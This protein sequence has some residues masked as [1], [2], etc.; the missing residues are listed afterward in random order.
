MALDCSADHYD[1][2]REIV[3]AVRQIYIGIAVP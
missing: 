3:D 2:V 1:A